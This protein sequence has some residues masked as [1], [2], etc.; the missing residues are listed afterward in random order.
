MRIWMWCVL[1]TILLWGAYIPTL[2]AGQKAIGG[3]SQG[4]WAFLLV[5]T[6]Y[7]LVS[8]LVP[9]LLLWLRGEL[10]HLPPARGIQLAMLAGVVGALGA[11]GV[12]LAGLFGGRPIV[13]AP[14]V[15]VGT[16]IVSVVLALLIH[17]PNHPP[18]VWFYVG[19]V[20]AAAGT[21]LILRFRPV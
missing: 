9:A 8:I 12:I 1:V 16:P 13:V 21:S 18:G 6:A 4:L 2:H 20:L 5:G 19:I 11:L 3:R 7:V 10:T 17:R 14:L 15:F